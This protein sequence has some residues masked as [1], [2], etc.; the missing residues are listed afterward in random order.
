MQE[1]RELNMAL[2]LCREAASGFE[3][4]FEALSIQA[5]GFAGGI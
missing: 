4:A 1:R 5:T 3:G 2:P